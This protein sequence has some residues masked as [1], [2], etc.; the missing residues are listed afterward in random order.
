MK[1]KIIKRKKERQKRLSKQK[2]MDSF[3]K[4]VKE[5]IDKNY[6]FGMKDAFALGYLAAKYNIEHFYYNQ[7]VVINACRNYDRTDD[8]A[9]LDTI[10]ETLIDLGII[11]N[12]K[13]IL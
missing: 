2:L 12:S 9:L 4:I 8:L 13:G 1:N 10:G 7:E 3:S 6:Q 11:D 5:S